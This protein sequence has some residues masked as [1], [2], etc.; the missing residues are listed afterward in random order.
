MPPRSDS[1]KGVTA[2]LAA[3]FM[4]GMLYYYATLLKPLSGD[5]IFGWRLLLTLPMLTALMRWL[6]FW[7]L[8]ED[9]AG[10]I[11]RNKPFVL[12]LLLSSVLVGAQFWLFLWAPVNGRA[13]QVSLGY[14]L[15]PLVMVVVGRILFGDRLRPYQKLAVAF[16]ALGVVNQTVAVGEFS[17]EIAL[18]SL[19]FPTYFS[20]RRKMGTDHLGG[21]WFDMLFLMP[22]AFW[23][24][25]TGG[26]GF[27]VLMD[28]PRMAAMLPLLGLASAA[29]L[30]SYIMACRYLSLSIFG[31]LSYVEPVLL[32][33][34]SLLL[35]ERMTPAE[36]PTFAGVGLA[37][38]TLAFGGLREAQL[39]RHGR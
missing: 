39:S 24:V 5:E 32:V 21:L 26:S 15:M 7:P 4:F 36:I 25:K 18:V 6:G 23:A 12:L 9:I 2:S 17:W 38:G 33:V 8:A 16:A 27:G 19:G 13:L 34:V 22:V 37:V 29:S 30:A 35:G 10:R 31:L 1:A 28:I 11:M 3:S 14:L 20:L